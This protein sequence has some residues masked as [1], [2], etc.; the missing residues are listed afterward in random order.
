MPHNLKLL[1]HTSKQLNEIEQDLISHLEKII[2][3]KKLCLEG[4]TFDLADQCEQR[5]LSLQ[6]KLQNLQSL[7]KDEIHLDQNDIGYFV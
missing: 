3:C 5:I 6:V 4:E 2:T 1:H 7:I